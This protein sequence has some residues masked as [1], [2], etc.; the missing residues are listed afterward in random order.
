M[1]TINENAGRDR[2]FKMTEG[3]GKM[4]LGYQGKTPCEPDPELVKIDADQF[5][6]KPFT[7]PVGVKQ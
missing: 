5:Q 3:Y 1:N 2:W 7:S 6:M 4:L